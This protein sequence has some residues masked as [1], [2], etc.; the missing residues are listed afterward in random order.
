MLVSAV[1]AVLLAQPAPPAAEA[2]LAFGSGL[3]VVHSGEP[4]GS[5]VGPDVFRNVYQAS[6]S[7]TAPI[8][9]GL[10]FEA[11]IRPSI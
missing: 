1:I 6:V 11:G 3:D 7:Y 9:S 2:T 10:L 8:G 4:T 5:A